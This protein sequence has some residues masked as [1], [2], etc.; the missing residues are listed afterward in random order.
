MRPCSRITPAASTAAICAAP[1]TRRSEGCIASEGGR[2]AE[3]CRTPPDV[4]ARQRAVR[5]QRVW[6]VSSC[7]LVTL[8][9]LRACPPSVPAGPRWAR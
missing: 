9:R 6:E 5:P 2:G 3:F 4:C 8:S 1:S 7:Y